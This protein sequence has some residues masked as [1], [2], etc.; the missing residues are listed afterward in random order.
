VGPQ[1]SELDLSDS[2]S[3]SSVGSILGACLD[4]FNGDAWM[5]DVEEAQHDIQVGVA[6]GVNDPR[7]IPW[8][9]TDWSAVT[10]VVLSAKVA[11]TVVASRKEPFSTLNW[12]TVMFHP[13]GAEIGEN[14]NGDGAAG[15]GV[16]GEGGVAAGGETAEK[17]RVQVPMS[18]TAKWVV[19]TAEE[20]KELK[21]L[22][23]ARRNQKTPA[24]KGRKA[25]PGGHDDVARHARHLAMLT[26]P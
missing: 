23:Q 13:Q 4:G 9:T 22:K 10:E 12:K 11:K 21:K 20:R 1:L 8:R 25:H 16:A 26:Q 2:V 18:A 14:V 3:D 19:L 24:A 6:A 15:G 5:S 17:N 7:D